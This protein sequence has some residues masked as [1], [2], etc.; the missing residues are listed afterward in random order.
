[1]LASGRETTSAPNVADLFAISLAATITAPLNNPLPT[2]LTQFMDCEGAIGT[3]ACR[4]PVYASM[5]RATNPP[6]RPIIRYSGSSSHLVE[7][8]G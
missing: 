5:A 7:S 3:Q 6:A 2:R 4:R 8:R 1:M